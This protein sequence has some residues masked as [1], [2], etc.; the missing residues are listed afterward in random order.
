M[1]DMRWELAQWSEPWSG[2]ARARASQFKAKWDQTLWLLSDE[3]K[4]LD[5]G[6]VTIEIDITGEKALARHRQALLQGC[7]PAHSGVRVRFDCK[8]GDLTYATGEFFNWRDNVRAIALSLEALRA[9]DRYGVSHGEQYVGFRP[10]ITA[11]EEVSFASPKDAITWLTATALELG[12]EPGT[13]T[14]LHRRLGLLLHPDGGEEVSKR[15]PDGLLFR[16]LVAA[17]ESLR[18]A[19]VM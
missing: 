17:K 14:D 11:G 6:L 12:A 15:D 3:T 4:R 1:V 2:P 9:V 7:A 13:P 18:E 5:A 8:H 19:G 16:R 10:A